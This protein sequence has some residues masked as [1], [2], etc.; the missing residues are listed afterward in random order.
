M[1]NQLH[2]LKESTKAG[3]GAPA[4][5]K[6]QSKR[7]SGYPV[8]DEAA[9]QQLLSAAYVMQE[10][11]SRLKKAAHSSALHTEAQ[12]QL[13]PSLAVPNIQKAADPIPFPTA[14]KQTAASS[15][16]ECGSTLAVNEFFCENCGAPAERTGGSMQKNWASLWEMHH[17]SDSEDKVKT[18]KN[19]PL[20]ASSTIHSEEAV[21]E[22]ID[23]FP[24]ELEEI[25][26]KFS[27]PETE[28]IEPEH[29]GQG[30][31]L[32]NIAQSADSSQSTTVKP[33]TP[34]TS[35]AK[36]R[37]WLD[38][39]KVQTPSKD[40]FR[41]EWYF[42][43]GTI[44]IALA[45]AVLLAVIFQ[46]A[47]QPATAPGQPRQ[48]SGFEQILVNLGLAEAPTPPAMP[49]PG[50]PNTK[51]WVDVHTALYYCPGADLYGKTSDG[52]YAPQSDAQ[53]DHFQ[54]STLKA[55]D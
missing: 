26:G 27:E 10:H 25:V 5:V 24:A 33:V 22:E 36:A 21:E 52:R 45:S 34:W 15:C 38:S 20:F 48:L 28:A 44:S 31:A 53:R 13:K 47:T 7:E 18:G 2:F 4:N 32:I 9:F 3:D 40:W 50:N 43:R 16:Q 17:T 49:S 8:V 30:L 12:T 55:C 39:L 46:W 54:P 23:L 6:A 35:A 41:E 1:D 51:V 11:N 42:H 29:A 19:E 37:A 14:E